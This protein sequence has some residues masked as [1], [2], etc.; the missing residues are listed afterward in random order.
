MDTRSKLIKLKTGSSQI[1]ILVFLFFL[2]FSSI[3]IDWWPANWNTASRASMP[4]SIVLEGNINIDEYAEFTGDK[5]TINGHYYSDKGPSMGFLMTPVIFIS[6]LIYPLENLDA[7]EQLKLAVILGAI[8]FGSIPFSLCGYWIYKRRFRQDPFGIPML[9][10]FFF[11]SFLFIYAGSF[12]SHAFSGFLLL[13][14]VLSL[15]REKYLLAGILIGT[16]F[17]TEYTLAL[18]GFGIGFWLLFYRRQ[19]LP[20]FILGCS[21][22]IIIQGIYNYTLTGSALDFAY[23]YQENFIQNSMNYGFST[24]SIGALYDIT[25][26]PYRGLFFYSPMLLVLIFTFKWK[27]SFYS[28]YK[29]PVVLIITTF[30]YII[31]F[32]MSKSWHG[33]WSYGPRY[34][35]PLPII[36]FY[37][38]TKR[39]VTNSKVMTALSILG[40]FG[41]ILAFFDKATV[42]YPPT[43][44]RFPITESI[45]PAVKNSQWNDW[46]VF[47]ALG[48]GEVFS[49]VLFVFLFVTSAIAITLLHRKQLIRSGK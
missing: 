37:L 5:A 21:I 2:L 4:L 15:E 38:L 44:Y 42:L 18:F 35:Y 14:S 22:L 1:G 34:L 39:S 41:L 20:L 19:G 46:N 30:S 17:M 27:E 48:L 32:S 6:D 25:L 11:G 47:S 13:A 28:E 36:L 3:Y 43:D 16:A 8:L 26:A 12:Y 45:I 23:K 40:V 29:L 9:I 33:G 10:L 49:F 24:P 7:R 31:L